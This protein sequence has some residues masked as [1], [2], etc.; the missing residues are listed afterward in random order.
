MFSRRC[1]VCLRSTVSGEYEFR[2]ETSV[3]E[4]TSL[5][6]GLKIIRYTAGYFVSE[7]VDS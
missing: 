3:L 5:D 2:E 6:Y 7:R 1:R 4:A